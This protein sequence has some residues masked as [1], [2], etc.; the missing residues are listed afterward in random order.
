MTS[1][2]RLVGESTW[3]NY[4]DVLSYIKNRFFVPVY[5]CIVSKYTCYVTRYG[6]GLGPVAVSG[7]KILE[8][9]R[10]YYNQ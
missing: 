9:E 5:T 6:F 4:P 2:G 7:T 1:S 3:D 10:R 8:E